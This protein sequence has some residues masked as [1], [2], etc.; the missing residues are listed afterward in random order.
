MNMYWLGVATLAG[1]NLI[2][3]LGVSILTGFTGL[4]SM[5]HAGFMC[6]G[7]YASAISTRLLG[8]PFYIGLVIGVI[9]SMIVGFFIGYSTLRLRG[10]YFVIATL[11]LGEITKL[12]V[13]NLQGITGGA[14]GMPDVTPGTTFQ[15]VLV[16]DIV[17][18]I[19]LVNFLHSKHGRNCIAIREEE[20]AAQVI[21]IDIM[22]YKM[23]AMLISCALC[24]L[25]GGLMAHYMHYL[26]PAMFNM[27]KSNELII[28]VILGGQGSLSGT[29]LATMFLVFLPELLRIGSA[30]E[31]RMLLYG[32][33]VVITIIF[34][35]SGLMGDK[36]ISLKVVKDK[37]QI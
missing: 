14:K 10:D 30:Q 16:L 11:A 31:W 24:G 5:G 27:A 15:L 32:L 2:A 9:T 17:I 4:F 36:E 13:E 37:K 34:R 19:M 33:L 20:M 23:I 22:R 26:H 28:M 3:T 29:I 35:P 1:I 25:S 12:V 8:V 21:G 7:A 6:I 18:I